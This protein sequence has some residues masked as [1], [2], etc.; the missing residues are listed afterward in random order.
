MERFGNSIFH[1]S[2]STINARQ[3]PNAL[4]SIQFDVPAV[5]DVLK[6]KLQD[7]EQAAEAVVKAHLAKHSEQGFSLRSRSLKPHR[8]GS[9]QQ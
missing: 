5:F 1:A 9:S 6:R 3:V 8:D 4:Q 7:V 2:L